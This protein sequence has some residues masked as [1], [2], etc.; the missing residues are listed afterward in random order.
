MSGAGKLELLVVASQQIAAGTAQLVVASRVK[1]DR[2][3]KNLEAVSKASRGVSHATGA[4]VAAA[5]ACRHM[6]ETGKS[7][8]TVFFSFALNWGGGCLNVFFNYILIL[9][10]HYYHPLY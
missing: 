9:C 5:K 8:L 7:S 10:Y 2:N 1:A 6:V 3:S 4:V